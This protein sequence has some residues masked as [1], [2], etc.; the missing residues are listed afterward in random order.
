M[1]DRGLNSLSVFDGGMQTV[2]AACD[3]LLQNQ[4]LIDHLKEQQFSIAVVDIIYNECGLAL[5]HH[6]GNFG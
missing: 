3:T 2:Q 5:A 4:K 1:W 6:L